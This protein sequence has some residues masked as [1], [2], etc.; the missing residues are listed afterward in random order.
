MSHKST[1]EYIAVKR[2]NTT[3]Q[4]YTEFGKSKI[5]SILTRYTFYLTNWA[6]TPYRFV[7]NA[8]FCRWRVRATNPPLSL[9]Y[10][11]FIYGENAYCV[12]CHILQEIQNLP[13]MSYTSSQLRQVLC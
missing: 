12:I 5:S 7:L 2:K 9:H 10:F 4:K 6:H 11:N 3:P 8:R 13:A 1:S